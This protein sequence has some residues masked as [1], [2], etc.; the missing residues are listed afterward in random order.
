MTDR[1]VVTNISDFRVAVSFPI[2][3]C[4]ARV[5]VRRRRVRSP[6]AAASS[7]RR[8]PPRSG[9][10]RSGVVTKNFPFVGGLSNVTLR[11]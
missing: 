4:T 9:P 7:V 8:P 6:T 1:N 10:P 11:Q 5:P 3:G 2:G